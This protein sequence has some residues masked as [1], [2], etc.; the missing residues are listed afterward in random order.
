VLLVAKS[1]TQVEG[2]DYIETF[3]PTAKLTTLRCLFTIAAARNWFTY[4]LDVK[5]TFLHGDLHEIVYIWSFL[6]NFANRGKS[7]LSTS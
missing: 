1:Y 7:G 3:S 5:N 6:P 2:I 4:Q